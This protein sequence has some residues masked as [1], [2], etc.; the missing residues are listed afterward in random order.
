MDL[1]VEMLMILL[2]RS[3]HPFILPSLHWEEAGS[4]KSS[5]DFSS[6]L[7]LFS[8]VFSPLEGTQGLSSSWPLWGT[9]RGADQ[10]GVVPD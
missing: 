2:W 5:L 10:G 9:S 3:L 8:L 7:S 1:S 6:L 4:E